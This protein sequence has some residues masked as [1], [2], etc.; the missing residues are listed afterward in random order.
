MIQFNNYFEAKIPEKRARITEQDDSN[1][2]W[3]TNFQLMEDMLFEQLFS[4]QEFIEEIRETDRL[5]EQNPNQFT[6][7]SKL[8]RKSKK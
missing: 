7:L 8:Y 5:Y 2:I 6:S 3:I 4:S 1:I